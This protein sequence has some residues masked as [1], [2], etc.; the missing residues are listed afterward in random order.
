MDCGKTR[1]IMPKISIFPVPRFSDLTFRSLQVLTRNALYFGNSAS[2]KAFRQVGKFRTTAKW[3]P[4]NGFEKYLCKW[5]P[6][7]G[8]GQPKSSPKTGTFRSET[9]LPPSGT[10]IATPNVATTSLRHNR[11]QRTVF[12]H[13]K[14]VPPD[15]IGSHI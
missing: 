15:G 9:V 14:S 4:K 12:F 1:Q 11:R 3:I 10:P 5:Y 2:K 13:K 7:S 8:K 6:F